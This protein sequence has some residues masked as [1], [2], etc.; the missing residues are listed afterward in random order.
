[1]RRLVIAFVLAGAVAAIAATSLILVLRG[2]DNSERRQA[3]IIDQLSFT[4]P[5]PEFIA[6]ATTQLREAGYAV[7]YVQ[8]SQV[9]VDFYRELPTR[10]YDLIIVRSHS[11]WER[12]MRPRQP[13]TPGSAPFEVHT[14]ESGV[15]LFTNEE[16]SLTSHVEEQRAYRLSVM[17]YPGRPTQYFGIQAEFVTDEMRGNFNGATV[18]L[19][20]CAGL[21]S[22]PMAQSLVDRGVSRFISWDGEVTAAHTDEVTGRLLTYLLGGSEASDAASQAMADVGP[23]PTFGSHLSAYP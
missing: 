11:S 7:D 23:D 2:D 1:V 3:V 21:S 15:G 18:V 8:P 13:S 4:D 19:M 16:Y 9:T 22:T 12:P 20:G 5:H 14:F 6:G 17:S 10:N